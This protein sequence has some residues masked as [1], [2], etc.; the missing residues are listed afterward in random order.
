MYL[1]PLVHI[2]VSAATKGIFCNEILE[3]VTRVLGID[4]MRTTAY[5][6]SANGRVERVHRTLNTL[7]SKIISEHHRDWDERLPIC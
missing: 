3:D 5:R 7:L 1:C 2:A 4:K 6:A